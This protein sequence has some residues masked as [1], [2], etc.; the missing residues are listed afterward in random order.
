MCGGR[1]F[2][3]RSSWAASDSISN[4]S[5][6]SE[7][8]S[9]GSRSSAIP[10]IELRLP[11]SGSDPEVS[12]GT[13]YG[14]KA[15]SDLDLTRSRSEELP[16]T[17]IGG[18]KLWSVKEGHAS[19]DSQ[20]A[21]GFSSPRGMTVHESLPRSKR[22]GRKQRVIFDIHPFPPMTSLTSTPKHL[23]TSS[24]LEDEVFAEEIEMQDLR[25][26]YPH[27]PDCSQSTTPA[28]LDSK[29]TPQKMN[30][31]PCQRPIQCEVDEVDTT[32]VKS[33]MINEKNAKIISAL[34]AA[35]SY[36]T[37]LD[38]VGDDKSCHQDVLADILPVATDRCDLTIPIAD[39]DKCE[40]TCNQDMGS[41][42]QDSSSKDGQ[43]SDNLQSG[44]SITF[45]GQKC[46]REVEGQFEEAGRI[47]GQYKDKVTFEGQIKDNGSIEAPIEEIGTSDGRI[48]E[49]GTIE[50]QSEG[51]TIVEGQNEAGSEF[52]GQIA[53][54]NAVKDPNADICTSEGL[55]ISTGVAQ[56]AN[57]FEEAENETVRTRSHDVDSRAEHE[58]NGE[59][60]DEV[61]N[62]E[63]CALEGCK[64]DEFTHESKITTECTGQG[65]MASEGFVQGQTA[66]ECADSGQSV[67]ECTVEG[68][69]TVE[70]TVEGQTKVECT[71]EGQTK[72]ECTVEGQIADK[73][74]TKGLT[75]DSCTRK[76]VE[77]P[78]RIGTDVGC[79][80]QGQNDLECVIE[81]QNVGQSIVE[82]KTAVE[83]A[84]DGETAINSI[85]ECQ[86]PC[87]ISCQISDNNAKVCHT[88]E[89]S[90]VQV[91]RS[92][93][94]QTNRN[95]NVDGCH[96]VTSSFEAD[97]TFECASSGETDIICRVEGQTAFDLEDQGQKVI[98]IR[99][100]GRTE[101]ENVIDSGMKVERQGVFSVENANV[102]RS[103]ATNRKLPL[104]SPTLEEGKTRDFNGEVSSD[105]RSSLQ[106]E[107]KNKLVT[108]KDIIAPPS[109]TQ[110]NSHKNG[111]TS[112]SLGQSISYKT[113][114]GKDGEDGT[115]LGDKVKGNTLGESDFSEKSHPT[116]FGQN[117]S[118][119][120]SPS[121]SI[122]HLKSLS[123]PALPKV[124]GLNSLPVIGGPGKTKSL[125]DIHLRNRPISR[126]SSPRSR[127]VG[128]SGIRNSLSSSDEKV[129]HTFSRQNS[130]PP[131]MEE[132]RK[133]PRTYVRQSSEPPNSQLTAARESRSYTRSSRSLP[134]SLSTETKIVPSHVSRTSRKDLIPRGGSSTR[135]AMTYSAENSPRSE[136]TDINLTVS[137]KKHG[138]IP[139]L[140]TLTDN[141]SRSFVR[142]KSVEPLCL[143]SL[144]PD[145][146][147]IQDHSGI[148]P[149]N[150]KSAQI[151]KETFVG[152][153]DADRPENVG[154][155]GCETVNIKEKHLKKTPD[156][157]RDLSKSLV[158]ID[159]PQ[160]Q[161]ATDLQVRSDVKGQQN[162]EVKGQQNLEV[163]GQ[164]N[165]VSV[166]PLI[167]NETSLK[168]GATVQ[169]PADVSLSENAGS[170]DKNIKLLGKTTSSEIK[171][172]D[173]N[174][175]T[176]VSSSMDGKTMFSG[177][178]KFFSSHIRGRNP[179]FGGKSELRL[180][181]KSLDRPSI[182][183]G[184]I[185]QIDKHSTVVPPKH[186][187]IAHV[188]NLQKH[189]NNAVYLPNQNELA[190]KQDITPT[191]TSNM[192]PKD[193]DTSIIFAENA[194]VASAY[195]DISRS[196]EKT[197][198]NIDPDLVVHNQSAS[199][200][201]GPISDKPSKGKNRDMDADI[202][203]LPTL[204]EDGKS[205]SDKS[206]KD[207]D[208]NMDSEMDVDTI[209]SITK[210]PNP[211]HAS[212]DD[213][214]SRVGINASVSAD[215]ALRKASTFY[216]GPQHGVKK[217]YSNS[218]TDIAYL[219]LFSEPKVNTRPFMGKRLR[220][221]APL[222]P[223]AILSRQ[224]RPRARS[225]L[226]ARSRSLDRF[227]G[228][229]L[230]PQHF[231]VEGQKTLKVDFNFSGEDSIGTMTGGRKDAETRKEAKPLSNPGGENT[232]ISCRDAN[233]GLIAEKSSGISTKGDKETETIKKVKSLSK[234]E[235][236]K[237]VSSSCGKRNL[238]AEKSSGIA[239]KDYK[240]T[241]TIN[242]VKSL[243]KTGE[244]KM[245]STPCGKRNLDAEKSSDN[246]LEPRKEVKSGRENVLITSPDDG[247]LEY[248][249]QSSA[250]IN[251]K[252]PASC[253]KRTAHSPSDGTVV[254]MQK[255]DFKTKRIPAKVL[256]RKGQSPCYESSAESRADE[257]L[258]TPTKDVGAKQKTPSPALLYVSRSRS[259]LSVP[260]SKRSRS[261]S[262]P[263]VKTSKLSLPLQ[264]VDISIDGA[265]TEK[266][267]VSNNSPVRRRS[268]NRSLNI[269]ETSD[270]LNSSRFSYSDLPQS[271]VVFLNSVDEQTRL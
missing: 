109:V 263:M 229:A 170:S 73:C 269:S 126:L 13:S 161:L 132:E 36:V 243:S 51:D 138:S 216:P 176:S 222:N 246:A 19:F 69:T 153:I 5:L 45:E 206:H 98:E 125:C 79:V 211:T 250:K 165:L 147:P 179:V 22:K 67:V 160:L 192:P 174:P 80:T 40:N 86:I 178:P 82:D 257:N 167:E 10:E 108:K 247:A 144:G 26:S 122:L 215:E 25:L 189:S 128:P 210:D 76:V 11:S 90:E 260:R 74:V 221:C 140:K 220:T 81:G 68:Q 18:S 209:S 258:S 89:T 237:M 197:S 238:N 183:Q 253:K 12:S 47:E 34:D 241:E 27:D 35:A 249:D 270:D 139:D 33:G 185:M 97:R 169:P 93:E 84:T 239:T 31:S 271:D 195:L 59:D 162:L 213:T 57:K 20:D 146:L 224:G 91:Q 166:V 205:T 39:K 212:L 46:E 184:Y 102:P 255:A 95:I 235:E 6:A 50:G 60:D 248:M 118:V 113:C 62:D 17:R 156:L 242:K 149:K 75:A 228:L 252:I 38:S 127:S 23:R 177:N 171:Y 123:L 42:A 208:R 227:T 107:S 2:R 87:Q 58:T 7:F 244:D 203:F 172:T 145:Y 120:Q 65:H 52:G 254:K 9:E 204:A 55:D 180:R 43:K 66:V 231:E 175:P 64:V 199:A 61:Y 188:S 182:L 168:E 28:E 200:K 163:K 117:V 268:R 70:Y 103:L 266:G 154:I 267:A 53:E 186:V 130:A 4:Y 71:V 24:D 142:S 44:I 21:S 37:A 56:K 234:S 105:T 15:M 116:L 181:S 194:K 104:V 225:D 133:V 148:P 202:D 137:T 262:P 54:K 94:G 193:I 111:N 119:A 3:K 207:Q 63:K 214:Q 265:V 141:V 196:L 198:R 78:G 121:R 88:A 230:T 77:C 32:V 30:V 114:A 223:S 96:I 232:L 256:N 100:Q 112:N 48:K 131:E 129:S 152:D 1:G 83:C 233:S 251:E 49:S 219:D 29:L 110:D 157:E 72:V 14:L 16:L 240:E 201:L 191:L 150:I 134:R 135:D 85:E 8:G 187:D 259:S 236:D 155:L 261:S 143:T 159:S 106:T 164:Q 124:R 218:T 151:V 99:G 245:V 190:K 226:F 173:N 264:A 101:D 41:N 217:F 158:S 115:S 136:G 92:V